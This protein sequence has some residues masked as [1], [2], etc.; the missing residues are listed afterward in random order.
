MPTGRVNARPMPG[1]ASSSAN[2]VKGFPSTQPSPKGR[3]DQVSGPTCPARLIQQADGSS[4]DSLCRISFARAAADRAA[5]G[6]YRSRDPSGNNGRRDG[7]GRFA[8]GDRGIP[9]QAEGISR[10]TDVVVPV[11]RR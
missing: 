8:T 2:R 1:S 4:Y 6:G 5:G 11:E 9:P 3:G 10:E 7:A